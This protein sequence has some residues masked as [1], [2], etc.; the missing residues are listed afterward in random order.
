MGAYLALR[1]A[2]LYPERVDRLLLLCPGFAIVERWTFLL[3]EKAMDWKMNGSIVRLFVNYTPNCLL[4]LWFA[5]LA[6][7]QHRNC[8]I[9]KEATRV[10]TT[11][12]WK[13]LINTRRS[14]TLN[15]QL[16]S[17]TVFMIKQVCIFFFFLFL[18]VLIPCLFLNLCSLLSQG[19]MFD[20]FFFR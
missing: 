17:Y 3:G 9:S 4:P 6:L 18:S 19:V 5:P 16:S 13:T 11:L 7:I 15:V 2:H 8:R 12:S 1:F 10:C 14:Q 20:L